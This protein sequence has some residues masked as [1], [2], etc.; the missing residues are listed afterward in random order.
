MYKKE[1]IN[2][3]IEKKNIATQKLPIQYLFTLRHVRNNFWYD[4]SVSIWAFLTLVIHINFIL[5]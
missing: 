2:L 5:F 4:M 3:L 1:N